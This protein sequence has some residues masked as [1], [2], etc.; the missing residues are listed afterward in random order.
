MNEAFWVTV[1]NA[2]DPLMWTGIVL[3]L[4]IFYF[5]IRDGIIKFRGSEKLQKYLKMFLL[6]MIPVTLL[7]FFGSEALKLVFQIPRPCIPCPADGCSI[8]CPNTFSFPSNHAST[9]TA[10]TTAIFLLMRKRR[11]LPIY[12]LPMLVAA[13]RVYLNVHTV[14]DV[15]AGFFLGI[16][17]TLIVWNYRKKI[18][19]WEEK[20]L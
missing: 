9:M 7:T 18:F 16:S 5:G 14:Q 4:I 1:T 17:I 12:V 19:K 6:I 10:I 20:R 13:S 11:Y 2:G 8:Y 15:V 3:S